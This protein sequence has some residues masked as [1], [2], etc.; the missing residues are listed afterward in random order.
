MVSSTRAAVTLALD[1]SA[2]E[3]RHDKVY[4]DQ[5]V[6]THL[7]SVNSSLRILYHLQHGMFP[8]PSHYQVTLDFNSLHSSS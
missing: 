4:L 1:K 7:V 2:K 6:Q 5:S 8:P 3:Y